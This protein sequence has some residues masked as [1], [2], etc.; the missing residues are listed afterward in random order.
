[1]NLFRLNSRL[2]QQRNARELRTSPE[3]RGEIEPEAPSPLTGR[4][5]EI[6]LL[7]DRWEQ[8]QEGWARSSL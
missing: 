2:K 4:D 6:G 1:M 7:E 5:T 8:A 3:S